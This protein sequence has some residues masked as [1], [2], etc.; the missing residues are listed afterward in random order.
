[1]NELLKNLIEIE[2]VSGNEAKIISFLQSYL[3]PI[4]P[5]CISLLERNILI[6]FH[7]PLPGPTVLF[8]SH[9]DTVSPSTAW[10][11]DPFQAV[12]EGDRIFGLG[13]NDALGSVVS[14]IQ[15]AQQ[16]KGKIKHGRLLI[17]LVCEEEK[18][19]CGF[20]KIESSLPRYDFAIF[21]EPTE[22]NIG[23]CMRGAMQVKVFSRGKSGHAARPW[24]GFNAILKAADDLKKIEGLSLKDSSPWGGATVVPTRVK[25]GTSDNQ[26]P[27]FVE[28]LLD[29]RPT[30]DVNNEKILAL[31]EEANLETEVLFDRRK[32]M[33]CDVE[34]HWVKSIQ[35]AHPVS[36]LISFGGSCDMAFSTSPSVVMGPGKS[37]RSHSADEFILESELNA[38]IGIYQHVI[39]E[40][41]N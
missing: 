26:I 6:D 4:F 28:T 29:I 30:F 33:Q 32:A 20:Q 39:M 22:M 24:E 12:Q 34:S 19:V 13:A 15:A 1:M 41:L 36:K 27:D 25:G 5:G 40:F 8:C 38:A 14:F 23:Y 37:E 11:R 31:L 3:E 17:A 35:K 18:G 2:S 16:I 10:T 21:G 7:S 9:I